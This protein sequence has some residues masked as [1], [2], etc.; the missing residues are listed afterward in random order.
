M[1]SILMKFLKEFPFTYKDIKSNVLN[2]YFNHWWGFYK[3]EFLDK[4]D[5]LKFENGIDHI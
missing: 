4:W 1:D 2:T 5:E 3:M